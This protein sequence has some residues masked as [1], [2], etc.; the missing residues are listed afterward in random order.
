MD[1]PQAGSLDPLPPDAVLVH[2]GMHKTGTTAL[3]ST[4]WSIRRDLEPLGVHYPG[5][6]EAHHQP[7]RALQQRAVGWASEPEAPP[8]IEVWQQLAEQVRSRPARV[9]VSSEFFSGADEAAVQQ[10]VGDLGPDRVHVVV[11]VRSVGPFAVSWWA[12]ALKQGRT[13]TL[14]EWLQE[15]FCR[16][17]SGEASAF[18]KRSDPVT[19]IERWS[20][21]V[22][23]DRLT[24]VAI[25]EGD[26]TLLPGTFEKLLDL[27]PGTILDRPAPMVNR[28]LSAIESELV[29]RVN[30]AVRDKLTWPEYASLIRYGLI[31]RLVEVRVPAADE[32]RMSLP[33]WVVPEV[34]RE[35]E[36][37]V[38]GIESLNV[39]VVGDL[40]ALARPPRTTGLSAQAVEARGVPLS[41][42]V[43][44]VAGAV[45]GA[46]RG[47]W[48]LD[49]P[50]PAPRRNR[51]PK[52]K[53]SPELMR[54]LAKRGRASVRRR[55]RG[56]ASL[57]TSVRRR[58]R[59]G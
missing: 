23:P 46:T 28:G 18:W 43:E 32:P 55:I 7:A 58:A 30:V 3:Q 33:E 1:R 42:A 12:Q 37:I 53:S 4:L 14:E 57:P 38:E 8:P 39:R 26:R 25:D 10:L 48:S 40:R 49:K 50:R 13:H 15:T 17:E 35:G 29:R 19:V 11:G 45:A 31:R 9:V 52:E 34:L 16:P 2:I 22:G 41:A 20:Q 44:A 24:V 36:R 5:R 59:G 56:L 54:I 27:P 51:A 47:S 21:V 6:N